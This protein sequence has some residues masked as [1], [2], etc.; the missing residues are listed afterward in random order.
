MKSVLLKGIRCV[1]QN[2]GYG[3]GCDF[4]AAPSLISASAP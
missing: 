3:Q 1:R 4:C 2:D